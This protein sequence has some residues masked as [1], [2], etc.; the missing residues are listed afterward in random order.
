MTLK[1]AYSYSVQFL[2]LNNVD[3][4]DFKALCICC[5]ILGIKNSEYSFHKEDYV[6]NKKL[7][8]MLWRLKS[9]EPLQYVLGKWDFYESEFFVGEGVLIPRAET[10][11]L[12][13]L[14]VKDIGNK[15]AEVFDLC[16]GSGCI[17]LS[18]ARACKNSCVTLFE[19]SEKAYEYLSKNSKGVHNAH[20]VLFDIK[21]AYEGRADIIVSNPPYIRSDDIPSLQSE[22]LREP[23]MALDGGADGLDF[24]RII[25]DN[26]YVNLRKNGTLY[27]EIGESQG[28]QIKSVL[29]NFKDI[30]VIKDVYGNDRIVKAVLKD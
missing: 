25:N 12:A 15:K 8:D 13:D 1:Q 22:V 28:E 19:K 9:G 29:T 18:I 20:P 14:V 17:G 11:E 24:Y 7:A 30:T 26:W 3:E 21:D 6:S 4:A 10:E 16:A 5:S 27:L 23:H 2:E